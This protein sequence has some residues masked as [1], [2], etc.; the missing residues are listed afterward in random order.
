MPKTL[1]FNPF[2]FLK[3]DRLLLKNLSN[4]YL[5]ELYLLRSHPEIVQ[6]VD[7][8]CD[9]SEEETTAFIKKISDG[10]SNNEF[11]YWA[12]ILKETNKLIGTICLWCFNPDLTS[13]EIGFELH[14]NYQKNGYMT[15]ALEQ[16][17]NYGLEELKLKSI[18]GFTHT[19]NEPSI[20]LMQKLNFQFSKSMDKNVIYKLTSS[21]Y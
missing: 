11:I 2:P 12:L 20:K 16:V 8:E 10:I 7:K 6:F 3:S 17:L 18:T 5:N 15:E 13:A 14:P 9:K 19:K 1:N 4:N 21:N